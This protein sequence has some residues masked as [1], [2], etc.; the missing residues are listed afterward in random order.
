MS[1]GS[2]E[3]S[4]LAQLLWLLVFF[5][6]DS[7]GQ[8]IVTQTPESMTVSPGD[9]VTIQCRTNF[10]VGT[11]IAWYQQ[12]PRQAPKLLIF[13]TSALASGAST[14]FQG[15]GSRLYFFL[16]IGGVAAEDAGVYYCQQHYSR[17]LTV[18]QTQTGTSL[19]AQT[20]CS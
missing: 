20:F 16:T 15:S 2:F 19:S 7:R 8:F 1:F 13:G 9:H 10:G 5:I 6:Q 14:R 12:K 11:S 17:P 4:S 3:R 18:I